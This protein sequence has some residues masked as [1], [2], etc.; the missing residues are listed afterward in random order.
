[1]IFCKTLNSSMVGSQMWFSLLLLE[2]FLGIAIQFLFKITLSGYRWHLV[3]PVEMKQDLFGTLRWKSECGFL[4]KPCW[5]W[6]T[7]IDK[8]QLWFLLGKKV[9]PND[10]FLD[11]NLSLQWYI[12]NR[13]DQNNSTGGP[14]MKTVV[15]T[16]FWEYWFFF[17]LST[18]LVMYIFH[19]INV[20]LF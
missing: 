4:E 3:S 19:N 13:R 11:L 6:R 2:W 1:M 9:H 12:S 14:G 7:G 16:L 5:K 18:F 17:Y 10:T 20:I 15:W 8:V